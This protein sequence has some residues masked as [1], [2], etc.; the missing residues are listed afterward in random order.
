MSPIRKTRFYKSGFP[1]ALH[2]PYAVHAME[3]KFQCSY[4]CSVDGEC[5]FYAYHENTRTCSMYQQGATTVV[6]EPRGWGDTLHKGKDLISQ[7][8][9]VSHLQGFQCFLSIANSFR[10]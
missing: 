1:A 5:D 7:V 2:G 4:A 6:Y 9:D 3:T 10:S 8:S